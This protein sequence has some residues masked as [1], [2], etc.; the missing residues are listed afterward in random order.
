[1]NTENLKLLVATHTHGSV[2]PGY[3]VSLALLSARL[4]Q[5]GVPFAPTL[6]LDS[7]VSR[8]RNEAAAA[9]LDGGFSHLL[10]I[11]GDI[12]FRPEA[13]FRLLRAGKDV[14]GATYRRKT[15]GEEYNHEF[16]PHR[17]GFV[18]SCPA[19]GLLKIMRLGTGFMMISTDA[20]RK[21]R[22]AIPE[23]AYKSR[24]PDGSWRNMWAFFAFEVHDTA[25]G[26]EIFS[27]DFNFCRRWT[28]LG[29]E[30]WLD[31]E[32]QLKHWGPQSWDGD[33]MAHLGLE[34]VEAAA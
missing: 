18:P 5:A 16:I 23:I 32:I 24:R 25:N 3:A 6:F 7:D 34:P 2:L 17:D 1:M 13:V 22:A 12:E 11:D 21:M 20:L 4:A 8:G 33:P 29:G 19:T 31:P 26:R 15:D 9:A 30:I 14:C 10:F 27:E 28:A